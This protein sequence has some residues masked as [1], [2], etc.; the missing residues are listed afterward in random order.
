VTPEYRRAHLAHCRAYDKA[1][2]RLNR[3][4]KSLSSSALYWR[5][6]VTRRAQFKHWRAN[7]REKIK[8]FKSAILTAEDMIMEALEG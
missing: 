6:P 3:E 2:N 1:W 5:D 4:R 8:R 7:N